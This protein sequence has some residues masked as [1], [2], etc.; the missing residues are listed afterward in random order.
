MFFQNTTS[1]KSF[2]LYCKERFFSYANMGKYDLAE[3]D[4][5]AALSI[6]SDHSNAKNYMVEVLIKSANELVVS[7]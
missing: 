3:N 4:L 2:V 1:I 6:K 7:S 5:D